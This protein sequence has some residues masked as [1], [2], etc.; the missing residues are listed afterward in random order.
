MADQLKETSS[1]ERQ[2]LNANAGRYAQNDTSD[3]SKECSC[4]QDSSQPRVSTPAAWHLLRLFSRAALLLQHLLLTSSEPAATLNHICAWTYMS[5]QLLICTWWDSGRSYCHGL[6]NISPWSTGRLLCLPHPNS[7]IWLPWTRGKKKETNPQIFACT[8]TQGM[9]KARSLLPWY[10]KDP[11]PQIS[12]CSSH[13]S[14]LHTDSS[15]QKLKPKSFPISVH[16]FYIKVITNSAF[17]CNMYHIL[18]LTL[19]H[20]GCMISLQM[21]HSISMRLN[22]LS[23]SSTVSSFPA[24]PHTRHTAVWGSTGC[25]CIRKNWSRHGRHGN[26]RAQCAFTVISKRR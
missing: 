26:T 8:D 14:S 1:G 15:V 23:S 2:L 16:H 12:P 10:I 17:V 9:C 6:V 22:L 18:V 5:S 20:P 19:R 7:N 25:L 3:T 13:T 21:E 11:V 24:S 4:S